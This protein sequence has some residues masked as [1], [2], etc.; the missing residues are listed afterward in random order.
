MNPDSVV[1]GEIVL[2]Q[3]KKTLKFVI[4]KNTDI[5]L[6]QLTETWLFGSNMCSLYF[7]H[8]HFMDFL[9]CVYVSNENYFYFQMGFG[10]LHIHVTDN[11]DAP[12]Q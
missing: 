5:F 9:H 6:S 2:L 10:M 7:T 12:P 1:D 11:N 3:H 4:Y 8:W